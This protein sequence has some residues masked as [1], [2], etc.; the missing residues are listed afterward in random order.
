MVIV[1]LIVMIGISLGE[2]LGDVAGGRMP[3]GLIGTLMLLKMPDVI[4][5]IIPLSIFVAIIWGTGRMYRDQEMAV[6]RASG[7]NWLML[8]R[9]LFNLLM[10]VAAFLLA[11]DLFVAPKAAG[12]VQ[13]KLEQAYRTAAE[14][15]LQ[16]GRFHVL[17]GGDLV[18]YVES[19][20]KD[21]RTLRNIFIQQRQN[22]R[23]QVWSA[24]Q[25]YYWLDEDTG[26]RY[27]TLEDGQITEGGGDALDFGIIHFTR[28]DLRLPEPEHRIKAVA[29]E[30]KESSDIMLS[31]NPEEIA[32]IQWR[33]S[34]A[35]A[36]I[37]LGLL[38]IPLS[39]SAPR[40]GRGGRVI[41]GIL[42][43]TVYAN[44]L[45]MWRSLIAKGDLP[46]A[47]GMWWV[48]LLV[49]IVALVWLKRQGRMVGKG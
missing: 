19:V 21:G 22:E 37:V 25:G 32:E 48:H 4:S 36:I 11:M 35:I 42:T 49:F 45:Y 33:V 3:S 43:Y 28:N 24:E 7:F 46:P 38:A 20:D 44:A 23:E 10:P 15:G 14:W 18:L 1:L 13:D 12:T 47:M 2:L 40:E 29:V 8:L 5:T 30:A 9:P 6:M 17:K 26:E 27:L 41:L 16:T 31:S 39:H 34:P